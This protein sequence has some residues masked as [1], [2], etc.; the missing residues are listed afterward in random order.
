MVLNLLYPTLHFFSTYG[1]GWFSKNL[2]QI[3]SFPVQTFQ[4]LPTS[5]RTSANPNHSLEAPVA[6]VW[7]LLALCWVTP[8]WPCWPPRVPWRYQHVLPWGLCL[9]WSLSAK[10]VHL[11]F[12]RLTPLFRSG[13]CWMSHLGDMQKPLLLLIDSS[14]SFM[15]SYST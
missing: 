5:L 9:F 7:H 6:G 3:L 13:L 10:L 4:R 15:F 8:F 12:H 2:K 11:G 14:F 1:S